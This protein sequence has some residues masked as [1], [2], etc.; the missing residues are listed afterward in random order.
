MLNVSARALGSLVLLKPDVERS[1][2]ELNAIDLSLSAHRLSE[3]SHIPGLPHDL[4]SSPGFFRRF[5][6]PWSWPLGV[7]VLCLFDERY[8]L[9]S[10]ILMAS[11]TS[12]ILLR[13]WMSSWPPLIPD[14]HV[15]LFKEDFKIPLVFIQV[16]LF[17]NA[18]SR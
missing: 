18:L 7:F 16:S 8:G 6:Y 5:I 15:E 14:G 13:S 17:I 2:G 4:L 10:R 3:V 1:L 9:S 11:S 12:T